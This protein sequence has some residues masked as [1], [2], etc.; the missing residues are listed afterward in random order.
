MITFAHPK[1]EKMASGD[2]CIE[3]TEEGSWESFRSFAEKFVQQIG[4]EVIDK[5]ETE[6]THLWKIEYGGV[7]LNFVYSD[8]PNGVS[9]EPTDSN[10]AE[11]IDRLFGLVSQQSQADGL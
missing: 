10:A 7:I 2:D 11:A 9:I 6:G 4:A 3:L 8:Y 1:K 5:T